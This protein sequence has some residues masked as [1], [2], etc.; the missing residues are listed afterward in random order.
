MRYSQCCGGPTV[1]GLNL[2]KTAGAARVVPLALFRHGRAMALGWGLCMLGFR[3]SHDDGG[4][5]FATVTV[6]SA[7]SNVAVGINAYI[8]HRMFGE[9]FNL[10]PPASAC[11]N[12]AQGDAV[13]SQCSTRQWTQWD[14]GGLV[15]MLLGASLIVVPAPTLPHAS[16]TDTER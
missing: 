2:M 8:A 14:L 13:H 5:Y 12:D 1:L 9:R 11:G 3:A 7:S 10:V 15:V 16:D 4:T 6:C